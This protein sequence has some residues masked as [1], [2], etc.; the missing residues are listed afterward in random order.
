MVLK[1]TW[2]KHMSL[3]ILFKRFKTGKIDMMT[4]GKEQREF[5]YEDWCK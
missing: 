3:Q 2:R 4:D 5:L 1:E